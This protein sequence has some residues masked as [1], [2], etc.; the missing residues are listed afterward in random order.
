[1]ASRPTRSASTNLDQRQFFRGKFLAGLKRF[2]R[3]N[4]LPRAAPVATLADPQQFAKL[5]RRLHRHDWVVYAKP[6]FGGRMQALRYLG[7]D[8][9]R[10]A[11]SNHGLLIFD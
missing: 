3:G 11:I 2:H 4:K 7:R 5:L 6:A 9:H 10:V 1:L 8:T